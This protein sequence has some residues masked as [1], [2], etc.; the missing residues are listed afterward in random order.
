MDGDPGM[1]KEGEDA[2]VEGWQWGG[3]EVLA[4]SGR[5]AGR[6]G[7]K[8]ILSVPCRDTRRI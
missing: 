3:V 6:G 5:R 7:G 1:R 8:R 2:R 4:E